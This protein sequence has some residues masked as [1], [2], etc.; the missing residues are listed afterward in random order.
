MS[1][2]NKRNGKGA[3]SGTAQ[4][5]APSMWYLSQLSAFFGRCHLD[6][7]NILFGGRRLNILDVLLSW[8]SFNG[9]V[10]LGS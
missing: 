5:V 4:L 1:L 8:H 2:K 6:R 10:L 3:R 9:F 7:L